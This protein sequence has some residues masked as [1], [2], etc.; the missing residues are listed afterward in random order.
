M[1]EYSFVCWKLKSSRLLP[2]EL[3]YMELTSFSPPMILRAS[4]SHC[5]DANTH[6]LLKLYSH[7][8]SQRFKLPL[9]ISLRSFTKAA[10]RCHA[11]P[12]SRGLFTSWQAF[13][14]LN[15]SNIVYLTILQFSN[16][17]QSSSKAGL[18]FRNTYIQHLKTRI[19]WFFF[20]VLD[21][22]IPCSYC[23]PSTHNTP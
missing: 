16:T 20:M 11:I 12:L 14:F 17:Q 3:L 22:K 1:T 19:F 15:S 21:C 6:M 5:Q 13:Y 8:P 18:T 7:L 23:I 4:F 10:F 9:Q 2:L